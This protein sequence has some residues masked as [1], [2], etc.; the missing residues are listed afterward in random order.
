MRANCSGRFLVALCVTVALVALAAAASLT[1]DSATRH[2][3]ALPGASPDGVLHVEASV[4]DIGSDGP[5]LRCSGNGI[6]MADPA[7]LYCEELGYAYEIVDTPEGQHGVCVF[8]DGSSCDEWRFL[9]G[10]CGESYSYCARQGYGLI[11]KTDGNNPF[12]REYSVCVH[13]GEEIGSVTELT[14][15]RE[16]ATRGSFA[17][18]QSPLPP[19]EGPSVEAQSP[20]APSSFDW[21][22]YGGQDWMTSVKDQGSCGSCWAFSAVGIVEPAYNI[23]TNNPNLDLDLSE[24][25]LVSD[26]LSGNTCCGGSHTEAL[27]F[28][29]DSGIPDEACLPYVDGSGCSCFP[30]DVCPLTCANSGSGVCSNATCSDRC[31]DWASRLTRIEAAGYVPAGSIKK[32][33]VEKGPLSAD[34]GMGG[35]FDG[36]GVY[37]CTD[38]STTSHSVVIAGYSGAGGY[39]IVKNSWGSSW[40]GNGYFKVGYGECAIEDYVYY[41]DV[42]SS[43]LDLA[44]V[45]DVTGSMEDDIDSVKASATD[46]VNLVATQFPDSRIGLA[47]YR[48]HPVWPY[49]DPG[50]FPYRENLNFTAD[51]SAAVAAIQALSV[52]GGADWDESVYSAVIGAM[53]NSALGGWRTD[54]AKVIIQMGDAP[55]HD[56]EPVTGYTFAD[57]QAAY[58]AWDPVMFSVAVG[59]DPDALAAFEE[60]TAI[61]GGRVFEA[62]TPDDVVDAIVDAIGH[63]SPSCDTLWEDDSG[64]GT[65]L[66]IT[67]SDWEFTWPGGSASGTADRL[68]EIGGMMIMMARM[69]GFFVLGFGTPPSGPATAFAIDLNARPPQI[70]RLQDTTGGS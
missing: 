30:S 40:N 23:S 9:E 32:D 20:S 21:R 55:P 3:A 62:P 69:P 5:A 18:E 7:T 66:C 39:W 65:A 60:M 6:G 67:G 54:A 50:D 48:D 11:T 2:A 45:I 68:T 34:M 26:C 1:E 19:A 59:G 43:P 38:D 53:Q 12:S 37:R 70:L 42:S 35:T 41:A 47:T 28:I 24:E 13:D 17:A 46:I 27:S 58:D 4:D 22:N 29:R 64:R 57:V 51:G 10:K 15:L 49:G 44:F 14:D 63:I 16:K 36:S 8:P 56:P 61:T 52:D 33:L 31:S 25:Y